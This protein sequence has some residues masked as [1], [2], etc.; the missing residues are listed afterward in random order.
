MFKKKKGKEKD[1]KAFT[2]KEL[3]GDFYSFK[4]LRNKM[5]VTVS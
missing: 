3:F 2:L 4:M 1:I 5:I